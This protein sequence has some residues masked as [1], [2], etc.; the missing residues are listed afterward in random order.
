MIVP[1]SALARLAEVVPQFL[2][3]ENLA[4]FLLDGL[5]SVLPDQ[6]EDFP[7]PA[8]D[9]VGVV[10]IVGDDAVA[11]DLEWVATGV[12]YPRPTVGPAPGGDMETSSSNS[13]GQ[14]GIAISPLAKRTSHLPN[15]TPMVY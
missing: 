12:G 5:G 4:G 10:W 2:D 15:A 8:N 3:A 13:G 9:V 7:H 14:S 1:E 11:V 6:F